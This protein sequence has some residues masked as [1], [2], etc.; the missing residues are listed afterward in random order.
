VGTVGGCGL[1]EDVAD[2]DGDFAARTCGMEQGEVE[3]LLGSCRR[4]SHAELEAL[5]RELEARVA[6]LVSAASPA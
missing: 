6:G 2:P 5:A 1:V 4:I 3:R